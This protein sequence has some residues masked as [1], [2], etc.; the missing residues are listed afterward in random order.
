MSV[1]PKAQTAENQI[2]SRLKD[3]GMNPYGKPLVDLAPKSPD[4]FEKFETVECAE[5]ESS[6][7]ALS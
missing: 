3:F 7:E 6:S 5:I 2:R 1:H 4:P